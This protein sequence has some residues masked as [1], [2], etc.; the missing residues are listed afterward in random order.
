M[1]WLLARVERLFFWLAFPFLLLFAMTFHAESPWPKRI[2]WFMATATAVV[3]A[4][5]FLTGATS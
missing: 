1:T 4:I 3:F 5:I 2:Y